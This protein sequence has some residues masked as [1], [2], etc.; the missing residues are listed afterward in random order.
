MAMPCQALSAEG[1][2]TEMLGTLSLLQNSICYLKK[3]NVMGVV[4]QEF[5]ITS[6]ECCLANNQSTSANTTINVAVPW[7]ECTIS[8]GT[9]LFM[10]V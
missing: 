7:E 3:L 1:Q 9:G 8:F 10:V 4:I 2:L 6:L 5:N